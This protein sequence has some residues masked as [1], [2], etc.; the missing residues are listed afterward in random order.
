MTIDQQLQ[1]FASG[2]Y[3]NIIAGIVKAYTA[4]GFTT[5]D[6][7]LGWEM[8]EPGT[9]TY[10]GSDPQTQADWVKAF[11]H[12]YTV[13]HQAGAAD[14]ATVQVIWNPGTTNYTDANALQNLYPGNSYVDVIGAD[15]YADASPYTDSTAPVTYHDW[16]TGAEDTSLSTWLANPTNLEH[17]W[18]DPAANRWSNDGS[19]GHSLSLTNL[20]QFAEAQGKAFAIAETGAGNSNGGGDVT[21]DP[22]FPQWLYQQLTAAQSAGLNIDFV[23]IW[24]ANMGGN[25]EFS[26][27]SDNKPLE[28]AA[29]AK[30]FGAQPQL[31][32]STSNAATTSSTAAVVNSASQSSSASSTVAATAVALPISVTSLTSAIAT[33]DAAGVSPFKG[34]VISDP[35][36]GQ[37]ETA[38]VLFE[39]HAK[40]DTDGSERRHGWQQDHQRDVDA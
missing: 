35:N 12:V 33:T 4:Q 21:D 39:Q 27:A 30:Y 3:D 13:L 37:T 25:Y 22:A 2:Q 11:Q 24:D 18:N 9:P 20:M 36:A 29:W 6:F 15:V 38:T 14:G 7:R 5:L 26:Q 1:A 23:S 32:T 28:A 8:N 17:F 31:A 16:A 34:L 40:W 19:G 10:I